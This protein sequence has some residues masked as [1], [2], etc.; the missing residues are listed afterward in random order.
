MW[1][2]APLDKVLE[3]GSMGFILDSISPTIFVRGSSEQ[4]RCG[5]RA[6]CDPSAWH[7]CATSSSNMGGWALRMGWS[8]L[9]PTAQ[10]A[11][12]DIFGGRSSGVF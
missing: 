5:I 2:W 9:L 11:C 1:I 4:L 12:S 10:L 8:A 6:T 7:F 3:S